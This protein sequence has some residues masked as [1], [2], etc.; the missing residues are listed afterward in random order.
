MQRP[1]CRSGFLWVLMLIIIGAGC[2]PRRGEVEGWLAGAQ[3][4]LGPPISRDVVMSLPMGLPIDGFVER[5]GLPGRG[6]P[7][8]PVLCYS[9]GHGGAYILLFRVGEPPTGLQ[10]VVHVTQDRGAYYLLPADRRGEAF[11]L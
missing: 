7:S 1:I 6:G 8:V 11:P 5:F 4:E 2:S 3:K 10:A 9:D